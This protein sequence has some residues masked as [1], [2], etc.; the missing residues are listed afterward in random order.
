M[1]IGARE[2]V[3]P[4]SDRL[5]QQMLAE[6]YLFDT[7]THRCGYCWLAESGQVLDFRQLEPF[8]SLEWI[9]RVA[10]FF[11]SRTTE[12]RRWL[13]QFTGGEPLMAPNLDVLCKSLFERNNRVAFYTALLLGENHPG[14]RFLTGTSAP[15]VDY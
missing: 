4:A 14:F 5:V 6:V 8:R 10:N 12:N 15:N 13:L 7:C 1:P 2:T 3:P 9:S 11:N